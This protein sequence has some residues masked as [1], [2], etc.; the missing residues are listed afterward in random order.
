MSII[1][2]VTG[3]LGLCYAT[4]FVFGVAALVLGILA[5]KDAEQTGDTSVRTMALIGIVLGGIGLA[6]GVLAVILQLAGVDV[7]TFDFETS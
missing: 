3:V 5:K 4:C 2:I 7:Y 1:S 6:L